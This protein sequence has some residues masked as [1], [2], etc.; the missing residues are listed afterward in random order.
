MTP[1]DYG[2]SEEWAGLRTTENLV[3]L[4][5]DESGDIDSRAIFFT[6]GQTLDIA[7]L[8]EFTNG[9]AVPKY[10]NIDSEGEQGSNNQFSDADYPMFRL[11]DAYLMYAECFLRGAGGDQATA[12][13]FVNELRERAYGDASGDITAAD[14]S[15]D[16]ILDER[17]RE[18]Y[19][20]AHRRVDL[21]RFG[22]YTGS[23]YV[24]PW[25]GGIIDGSGI[26]DHLEIFPIPAI[27][28]AANP[29]L[30]QN[31]EY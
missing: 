11:A 8:T 19:W 2:T 25:K 10:R 21:I 14:L 23:E 6:E 18:L 30:D 26:D 31:P 9:Y 3:Q 13:D 20:E 28:L 17:A 24:W 4:F 29:N 5:P 16:F 12:I 27:D 15:L 7:D 22:Q 1:A